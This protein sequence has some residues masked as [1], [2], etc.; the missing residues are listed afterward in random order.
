MVPRERRDRVPAPTVLAGKVEYFRPLKRAVMIGVM[1]LPRISIVIPCRNGA[2]YLE[3]AIGSLLG[4][5]YPNLELIVMDGGSTDGSLEILRR[6][7]GRFAYWTSGPDGGQAAAINAGFARTTGEVM[8]WLNSDDMLAPWAI[9]VLADVFGSCRGVRWITGMRGVWDRD[10]RLV[11]V[12]GRRA[13]YPAFLIRHGFFQDGALGFIQQESTF[14]RRD[15]WEE[16]GGRVDE[17]FPM[18][19]DFELWTRFARHAALTVVPTVLGGF[20]YHGDQKTGREPDRYLR[21]VEEV[22]AGAAWVPRTA[23]TFLRRPWPVL[24]SFWKGPRVEYDLRA[25]RWKLSGGGA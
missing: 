9:D 24:S 22:L 14:W 19:F 13:S 20:R 21:E 6:N 7:E 5:A 1:V 18:A 2:K 25:N 16:A 8:G 4:Q 11:A 12:D 17:R 23:G 10:D 15:L 3:R